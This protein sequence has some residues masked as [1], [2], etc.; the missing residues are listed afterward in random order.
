MLAAAALALG[1]LAHALQASH[2]EPHQCEE[3]FYRHTLPQHI[4]HSGLEKWCHGPA[5]RSY[6][7]LY[8]AGCQAS[9]YTALHLSHSNGWGKGAAEKDETWVGE[10]SNVFIPAL[11]RRGWERLP[12]T[13]LSPLQKVDALTA[14]LVENHIV[15]L[16]A[17]AEGEVY[18]QSGVG[19]LSNC[20]TGV[21]WTAV[22]CDA[23]DGAASFSIG[24]ILEGED[25]VKVMSMEK[26]EKLVGIG[27]LFSGGCGHGGDCHEK[28]MSLSKEQL[29]NVQVANKRTGSDETSK[30]GHMDPHSSE[31]ARGASE[32]STGHLNRASETSTERLNQAS[33]T[34]T[35]PLTRASETSTEP[36]TRASETSTEPLNQASET[37][38]VEGSVT[39]EGLSETS[40][41][42]NNTEPSESV[43]LYI[44]SSSFSLLCA[45]LSPII[46]TLTNLPSQITYVLQEDAA[47][48]AALPRD[49]LVLGRDL[50]C[51]VAS[52]VEN[53]WDILYQ[54]VETGVG[55]LYFCG[56]TLA[57]T[58]LLSCQEGVIGTGTLM[59]NALGLATGTT[60][61]VFETGSSLVGSAGCGLVEY[62]GSMGW[63]MGHQARKVGGGIG[64][65]LWRS[66]RGLGR[67]LSTAWAVVR[68]V[69]EN[70]VENVQEVFGGTENVVENVQEVSTVVENVGE[71]VPENAQEA[72]T[73]E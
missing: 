43:I 31:E 62:L 73:A 6:T 53:V 19:G 72:V 30:G 48:L 33:E 58:L 34:S 63:E 2:P 10:D 14:G 23:P 20:D 21:L 46:S 11:Y 12:S 36:L 68:G 60:E 69:L 61:Q 51:G 66:K 35:E 5:G 41:N 50:L 37:S 25:D 24:M 56:K 1:L 44:L 54:L 3:N 47:V 4:V 64:T 65:L 13:S 59:S 32:T 71:T 29:E 38:F 17:K 39:E 22:C 15:P 27:E 45:P 49:S 8:H 28:V 40:T 42:A 26:L 9:V 7:S 70:A 18:V 55:S 57:G 67:L 52:G 16:C